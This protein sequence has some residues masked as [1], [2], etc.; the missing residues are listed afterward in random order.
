MIPALFVSHRG[1]RCGVYQFGRRLYDTLSPS[2]DIAWHYAECGGIDELLSAVETTKPQLVLFNYHPA[3]LAWATAGDLEKLPAMTFSIFHETHQEAVDALIPG[4]FDCLLCPDPTL[5]PRNPL[6]VPVPR[7]TP[8]LISAVPPEPEVFTVG[9]FGFGTPGKG[10]ER[11]CAMVNDQFEDA[12][13]RINLPL[14]DQDT[15]VPR[16]RL[17]AIVRGCRQQVTKRSVRLDISHDFLDDE[18]LLRFLSE[19]TINAFLY[20]DVVGRGIASCTDYALAC[21]RPIAISHSSMFRHLHGVNPSI[22]AEDRPLRA[23]ASSGTEPLAHHRSAYLPAASGAA[24]N[25]AILDAMTA[26]RTSRAVPDGRGFNKILDDRS[27]QAYTAALADLHSLAPEVIKRKIERANIQ[28]AFA[29]DTA[30]RLVHR[31][32]EPRIL[33]VGSYEDTAVAALRA[34]GFRLDEVD[35]NV[36]KLDLKEFYRSA[37]A[38]QQSY[39]LI[40]CV[41]VLEHVEDDRGFVR[42]IADLLSLDGIAIFTV[43][44]SE[45]YPESGRKPAADFRLYT[46]NDL[47][48]RLMSALPDCALL[49]PPSWHDGEDDFEYEQCHYSFASWVFRRLS[50]SNVW[51]QARQLD[52]L[53]HELRFDSGPRSLRM[54][55]PVARVIRRF[56]E[57]LTGSSG[58]AV[59]KARKITAAGGHAPPRP[60]VRVLV[61]DA[62]LRRAVK[63]SLR[64][65]YRYVLRPLLR[66]LAR[67][68]RSFLL[69]EIREEMTAC[70]KSIEA[71]SRTLAPDRRRNRDR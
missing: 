32:R 48:G 61:A 3:T 51:Q 62:R 52:L 28:Q 46:T 33:A 47:C 57:A 54:V 31:F 39:D 66:P 17:E 26:R 71:L 21:G 45:R 2:R 56:T 8:P 70:T 30:E 6:A 63:S 55:L 60:D 36:N 24:W 69:A 59:E 27:R 5:L 35:P 44:F 13:I 19:N 22:C 40:L 1:Q 12:R 25:R 37:Q 10:F 67:R 53:I 68:A 38:I 4:P 23:I 14:H 49:D 50:A 64:P 29:L 65:F 41:S 15:M 20:D 43:D 18:A 11:L 9:S 58:H 16:E 34:K 7:F 42:M